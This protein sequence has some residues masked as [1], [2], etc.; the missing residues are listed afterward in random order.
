MIMT[1]NAQVIVDETTFPDDKFRELVQENYSHCIEIDETTYYYELREGITELDINSTEIK[2]LKGVEYF[3]ELEYLICHYNNQLTSLDVSKNTKLTSLDCEFNQLTSLDVSGCSEL[4]VLDCSANQLISLDVSQNY[5]LTDLDC[6]SNPLTFLDV[7]QNVALTELNCCSNQL[8]DLDVSN[9]TALETLSCDD[10]QLTDLALS[11]NVALTHLSCN[12]N[13]LTGL[14]LYY[15]TQLVHLSCAYNQLTSLDVPSVKLNSLYCNN[16]LLTSLSF[17]GYTGAGDTGPFVLDCSNNQLTWLIIDSRSSLFSLTCF[18]NQI[19]GKA[20]DALIES[21]PMVSRGYFYVINTKDANEGNVITKK[22]VAE[23]TEKGWTVYDSSWRKYE[24]SD[25]EI[26]LDEENFSDANFREALA[27]ILNIAVGDEISEEFI[28]NLT[29]LD[30]SEK[31]IAD[32]SG[33]EYFTAL[34]TLYCHINQIKN[35]KMTALITALPDLSDN[36]AKGMMRT[37][38]T[39]PRKGALY[40]LDFTAD[41]EQNVCTAEHV[42]A[43]NAKG[44][45]VYCKTTNGW[46]EY[47]GEVPTGIGTTL[48]DNGKMTNDN[49]YSIDGVKLSGE[50]TKKGLYIHKGKKVVK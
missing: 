7:S 28:K 38:G 32:L 49:Y 34:T 43:A 15:N 23:A 21:L 9:N 8:T 41:D 27:E 50:P 1:A 39:N 12:D 13:Q 18:H 35:E 24:G 11:E 40:A 10:N 29:T 45:T 30:V 14:S 4:K 33:I 19:K 46:Q 16:N 5:N 20:M 17:S 36:E 47:T 48:N 31:T 37:E 2:S 3:T 25:E 6:S 26:V 44:W 22:Q 42:A